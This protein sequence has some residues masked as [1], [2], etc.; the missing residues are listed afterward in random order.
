LGTALS[1]MFS[2]PRYELTNE[3]KHV[4]PRRR[5]ASTI[6][7]IFLCATSRITCDTYLRYGAS[8][9]YFYHLHRPTLPARRLIARHYHKC[10]RNASEKPTFLFKVVRRICG[11]HRTSIISRRRL[12]LCGLGEEWQ[13][14]LLYTSQTENIFGHGYKDQG[15]KLYRR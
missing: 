2:K 7:A 3:R 14:R 1:H 15:N 9:R 6:S 13:P 10:S 4:S 12:L 5:R 8:T 11:T